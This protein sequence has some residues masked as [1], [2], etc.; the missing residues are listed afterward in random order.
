MAGA[1]IRDLIDGVGAQVSEHDVL[2][3]SHRRA[4]A[5]MEEEIVR[6]RNET[7]KRTHR[8]EPPPQ[9]TVRSVL[10]AQDATL[11][12]KLTGTTDSLRD[13]MSLRLDQQS[14]DV[15]LLRRQFSKM[16]SQLSRVMA[17]LEKLS[18]RVEVAEYELGIEP[19]AGSRKSIH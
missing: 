10:H 4:L 14:A 15:Q 5:G 1:T 19:M 11:Q 9:E 3:D 8:P 16:E 17:V 6:A 13:A 18:S 2:L 7:A 12:A